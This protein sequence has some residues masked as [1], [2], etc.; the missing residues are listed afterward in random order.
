MESDKKELFL[1]ALFL[2]SMVLVNTIGTKIISLFE[3]RVSVGIFFMPILFLV[4]DI[5]GEVKGKKRAL[6]YVRLSTIMLIFLF[7]MVALCVAI[8]PHS[9]YHLDSEYKDIFG[10]TLRMTLASLISFTVSQ[11]IDILIFSIVKKITKEKHLWIRNNISTM[12]SQLFD[13]TIF[14]FIAFYNINPKFNTAFIVS[15]IIPYWIFKV[16]FALIDTPF[17]YLGVKWLK[18]D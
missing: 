1:F 15:L 14:M 16:I 17:C 4:T 7:L 6:Y 3:V 12:I 9:S 13:T 11:N 2:T 10:S 8:P 5:I 18:K